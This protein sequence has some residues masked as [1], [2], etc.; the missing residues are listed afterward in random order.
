LQI[1][2]R[3]GVNLVTIEDPIEI[4]IDGLNQS[5]VQPNIG[6]TFANGFRSILR[7]DPDIVMVGEIRDAETLDVAI[8]AALTGHLVL[9]T[10]HTNSAAQTI[11][12][13]VDMGEKHFLIAATVNAI[14]AQRL[15]RKICTQCREAYAPTREMFEEIRRALSF[16]TVKEIHNRLSPDILKNVQLFRGKGCEACEGTGYKGRIGLFEI[17][18]F[19]EQT[20]KMVMNNTSSEELERAA[21]KKGMVPLL[22]DG[23]MK[24]LEGK[25]T[26]EEVYRVVTRK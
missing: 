9:S 17:L 2:N 21:I 23:V 13:M 3:E 25:T 16:V 20:K 14:M 4:K 15:I 11:T 7:Q 6:Y 10:L 5:Q 8:E 12:R 24:V 22:A 1:L 26:L 19:D 18:V